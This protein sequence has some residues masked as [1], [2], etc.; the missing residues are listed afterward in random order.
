MFSLVQKRRWYF[1]I[2]AILIVPGILAMI[3]STIALGSPLR[4]SIDF[5]GGSMW[6]LSF[7]QPLA[8]DQ[9]R[10]F[11]AQE[12]FP[13]AT[14]QAVG[15][16]RSLSIR[17]KHMAV[18]TKR[19]LQAALAREF[20]EVAELRFESVGPIIGYETA[21]AAIMAILASSVA[22]LFFIAITFRKVPNAFRYGVCAI[23]KMLHDVLLL[24]GV[25]SMMGLLAGWEVNSL[26]LTAVLTVVGFSV[27][28][29]IVVF[30]RIRENI[31]R[32]RGESF[33]IIV[34]RSLLETLHRSLATQLNAIFVMVAIILFG[35]DTIRQFI[36]IMLIG[37]VTGT[38]SSLFFAVPLL[39]TWEKGELGRLFR[40]LSGR[41][42]AA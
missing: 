22:M 3:Y 11:L 27:Q 31:P 38:Y 12:G 40:R 5:T 18:E 15:G 32:R 42:S 39:V 2:S 6:E 17:T 37:M 26:F 30:D 19:S 41:R 16:D 7:S 21:R 35:G 1:V 24:L 14:V 8:L 9:V 33:E 23:A 25:A 20:G 36:S 4:L 10:A 28:D 29:V 13:D 34:N